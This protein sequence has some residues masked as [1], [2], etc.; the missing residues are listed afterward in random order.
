M[1][2][3]DWS[4][5][6]AIQLIK[7]ARDLCSTGKLRLHKFISNSK[8]ALKSIPKDECAESVKDMNMALG[9]PLMKRAL[10]VQWCVSSDDFQFR[11]TVK[12]HPNTRRVVLSTVASIYNPLGFVVPFILRG[13][14]IL[15]QLCRDKVT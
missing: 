12:E 14:Q 9:E 8:E 1:L 5:A 3:M 11:V 4:D 6:E 7:D 15:Q 13:K 2:M 10:G